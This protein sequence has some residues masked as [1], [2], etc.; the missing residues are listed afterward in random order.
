MV[1]TLSTMYIRHRIS[2]S[3][4][5]INLFARKSNSNQSIQ[6]VGDFVVLNTEEYL[7][8]VQILVRRLV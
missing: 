3:H 7:Q 1:L 8:I 6:T 4:M 2:H 5:Q